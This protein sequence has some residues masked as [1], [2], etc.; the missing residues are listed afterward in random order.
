MACV[1]NPATWKPGLVD[2]LSLG[3]LLVVALWRS[4]VRTKLGIDMVG[5]AEA[6][7]TRSSKEGRTGPGRKRSR[8]KSPC[9]AVVGLRSWIGSGWQP[10]QHSGTQSFF[11]VL[12]PDFFFHYNNFLFLWINSFIWHII[13]HHYIFLNICFSHPT[14]MQRVCRSFYLLFTG[15]D[16]TGAWSSIIMIM[17]KT[18]ISPDKI[19]DI[20]QIGFL[21]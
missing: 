1:C 11:A 20:I 15:Y 13:F 2:H 12:P 5:S 7:T 17:A 8:Q 9:G 10:G 6:R 19:Q 16:L 14:S 18:W 21:Q 4:G 3:A